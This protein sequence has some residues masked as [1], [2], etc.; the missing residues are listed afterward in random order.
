MTAPWKAK[1]YRADYDE[2][3][4]RILEA[5]WDLASEKG[6]KAITFNKVAALAGC[7]RST[8]YRYFDSKEQLLGAMMQEGM[9]ALG[10][11]IAAQVSS[12]DDPREQLLRGL[13]LAI[14]AVKTNPALRLFFF[15]EQTEGLELA[16][17]SMTSLPDTMPLLLTMDPVFERATEAKLLRDGIDLEDI[18]KWLLTVGTSLSISPNFGRDE[19]EDVAFLR[20]ML[21]PSIFKA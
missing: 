4:M 18:G 16:T 21:L 15:S 9:Y 20:R 8:V 19:N 5:A 14:I 2:S 12:I 7:V 17:L 13:Y 3:R 10:Q 6:L 11:D 1:R